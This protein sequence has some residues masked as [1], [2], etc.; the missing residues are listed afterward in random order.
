MEDFETLAKSNVHDR[1]RCNTSWKNNA[2]EPFYKFT[3]EIPD[4]IFNSTGVML[5]LSG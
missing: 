1:G 4:D 2:K 5:Q 3:E